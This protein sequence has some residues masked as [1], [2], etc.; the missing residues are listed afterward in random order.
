MAESDS[1]GNLITAPS[2]LYVKE[3]RK[4]KGKYED[5]LI[6]KNQLWSRRLNN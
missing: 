2:Q 6:L 3:Y 5:I 1:D 4:I